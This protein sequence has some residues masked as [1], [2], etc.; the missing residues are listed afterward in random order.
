MRE[1]ALTTY[2]RTSAEPLRGSIAWERTMKARSRIKMVRLGVPLATLL[3]LFVATTALAASVVH[4]YPPNGTSSGSQVPSGSALCYF[5]SYNWQ[6]SIG[7]ELYAYYGS[8]Q[9]N[10]HYVDLYGGWENSPWD[11]E[12]GA[13]WLVDGYDSNNSRAYIE[14][15]GHPFTGLD[16]TFWPYKDLNYRNPG[17]NPYIQPQWGVAESPTCMAS[18][19]LVIHGP[20]N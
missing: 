10:I 20:N 19:Y 11:F 12:W 9:V 17:Y 2:R 15:L 5:Q 3:T 14:P 1:Q 8:N 4:I 13:T 16:V 18:S 6:H 7:Y